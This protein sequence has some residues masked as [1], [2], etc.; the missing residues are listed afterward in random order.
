[1]LRV[2]ILGKNDIALEATKILMIN[3]RCDVVFVSPNNSDSGMDGWQKSLKKFVVEQKLP[4]V[5][6]PKIK[7]ED[8][9]NF[10]IQSR[11]DL[12]FSFQYDQ[13]VNQKVIDTAKFGAINLHFAPL[14]KYRGV[15]QIGLSILNGEGEFG[16]TIHYMDPGVD[17]G[18]IIAKKL[19]DISHL[20]SA[21]DLYDLCV[22]KGIEL[23]SENVIDILELKNMRLPQ[24]NSRASYFPAGFI[25]F[26]KNTISWNW[27]T[28]SLHNWV[29]AFI[30][31]PFQFP[32]CQFDGKVFEI[33]EASPDYR[34]NKFEKPGTVILNH[35]NYYKVATHD[36]YL[37]VLVRELQ[38]KT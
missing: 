33:T 4:L 13:I 21:R 30:F 2:G 34:K 27:N 19:F 16:V 3:P 20:K 28:R 23:F 22:L 7:S 8:S 6:F 38:S 37:N 32:I 12:L 5:S 24:D 17:T 25:D 11:I 31:P 1:M 15:S 29:R 35:G 10:L 9:I 18:D 26:K 36:G 14:P